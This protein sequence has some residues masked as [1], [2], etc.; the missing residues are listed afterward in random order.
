MKKVL[1]AVFSILLC[2]GSVFCFTSCKEEQEKVKTNVDIN[3]AAMNKTMAYSTLYEIQTRPYE[4][5]GKTI[6]VKGVFSRESFKGGSKVIHC[7][8]DVY[9]SANCCSAWTTFVWNGDLPKRG[10]ETTVTGV[11]QV[12]KENGNEYPEIQAVSV[13]F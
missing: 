5:E 7:F 11:V 10:A 13:K 4:Y 9:D 2:F 3:I 8:I 1:I 6:K 12:K